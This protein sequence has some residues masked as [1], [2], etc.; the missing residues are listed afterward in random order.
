MVVYEEIKLNVYRLFFLNKFNLFCS[1]VRMRSGNLR[2]ILFGVSR[3]VFEWQIY[4]C[5]LR[6]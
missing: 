3:G 2:Y 6:C 1:W 4:G 5:F